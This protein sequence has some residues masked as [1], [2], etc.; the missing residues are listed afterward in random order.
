MQ[1]HPAYKITAPT[2]AKITA[3]TIAK[4]TIK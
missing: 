4:V 1:E 3:P 2:K